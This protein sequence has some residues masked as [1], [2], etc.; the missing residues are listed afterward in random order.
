LIELSVKL[1]KENSESI[2]ILDHDIVNTKF[3]EGDMTELVKHIMIRSPTTSLVILPVR[4]KKS[5]QLAESFIGFENKVTIQFLSK[6][7][8]HNLPHVNADLAL[9][10][11]FSNLYDVKT[12]VK[13]LDPKK[14]FALC[15]RK[16]Q[17]PGHIQ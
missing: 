14:T 4:P 10:A 2:I 1:T 7:D 11:G 13:F 8:M 9:T 16:E 6:E 5:D 12:S 17:I 15:F 3:S